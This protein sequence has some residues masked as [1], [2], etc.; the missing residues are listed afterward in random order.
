[1]WLEEYHFDGLRLDAVH[2]FIDRS[3]IHFLEYLS[4]TVA[5]LAARLGRHLTLIAESDLNNPTIVRN[6]EADGYGID[7]QWNDD[8]H[9]ALHTILTGERNGYYEDFGSLEQLGK[10]LKQAYVYDGK[11][12]RHRDLVHGRPATGLPG[13]RFVGFAQNHD[14]IGNRARGERLGHLVNLG[15]QKIAAAVVLTAPFIPLLFQ[16]EEFGASSPFQYFSQHADPE[17]AKNVSEGRKSEF[18]AFGWDPK[19]IPDPQD[20]ATFEASK[21]KWEELNREPHASL[22]NWYKKLIALRRSSSDLT[23]GRLDLVAFRFD[24]DGKW[25]VIRRGAIEIACNLS[26]DRQGV[27]ITQDARAILASENCYQLRDGII[28]LPPDSVAIL[29]GETAASANK[30]LSQ[31]AS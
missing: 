31:H 18:E 28:E 20:P 14:Q 25:F 27:P 22:L 29:S 1:M 6:R 2:A 17:I 3:A 15:R 30:H 24:E 21:L 13:Y 5:D 26:S 19:E 8:F 10:A 12:S 23:D 9:H 4:G 7:A 11:Y 16:G